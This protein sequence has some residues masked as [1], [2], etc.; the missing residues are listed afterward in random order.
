M[1]MWTV[2][3]SVFAALVIAVVACTGSGPVDH[4]DDRGLGRD[5]GAST[6]GDAVGT[7]TSTAA[8]SRVDG[9][10]LAMAWS[11]EATRAARNGPTVL[12]RFA[13]A[14]RLPGLV[15]DP[16]CIPPLA[17]LLRDDPETFV[18]ATVTRRDDGTY[19]VRGRNGSRVE[20]IVGDGRV[21]HLEGCGGP[22]SLLAEA[23]REQRESAQAEARRAAAQEAAEREAAEREAAEREA[24]EREAAARAAADGDP[25]EDGTDARQ[26]PDDRVEVFPRDRTPS[27]SG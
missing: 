18:D 15:D 19:L 13:A 10:G 5:V 16:G 7:A 20:L 26:P 23:E 4:R 6:A 3:G 21:G 25:E 8:P 2:R 1:A 9:A 22:T 14:S 17:G 12:L 27:P 11:E 24:A